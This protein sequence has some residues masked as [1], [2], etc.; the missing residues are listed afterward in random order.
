MLKI[1]TESVGDIVLVRQGAGY[2]ALQD[3]CPHAD[4]SLSEGFVEDGRVVCPLHF[5]E[6]DLL[7]GA[8]HGG[9]KG[10]PR[11][12]AFRVEVE[13]GGLYLHVPEKTGACGPQHDAA[14]VP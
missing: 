4:A 7:S 9:P 1:S 2:F 6:F 3:K 5:A 12:K 14:H 10:C 8:V 13:D 11:A